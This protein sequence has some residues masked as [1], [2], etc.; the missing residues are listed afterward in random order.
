M[1]SLPKQEADLLVI[2]D[3]PTIRKLLV[4]L[5]RRL[6]YRARSASDGVEGLEAVATR[7]PDLILTDVVMPRVDGLEVVRRL[8]A[9]A[10]TRLIPVVVLTALDD[11]ETRMRAL[12]LGADELLTKPVQIRELHV[13]IR[14]LLGLKACIDELENAACVLTALAEA[15]EARDPHTGRHCLRLSTYSEILGREMNLSA[16]E[17]LALRHGGALH[18]L[19]KIAV[20]DRIL[21]KDGP[22]TPEEWRVMRLHTVVG[23]QIVASMKSM[24]LVAPIVRSHH[25][26]WDGTGY[27]DG[28]AGERIPLLARI[29]QV[30]DAYDAMRSRR[31]YKPPWPREEALSVLGEETG[32]GKWDPRIVALFTRAMRGRVPLEDTY[33]EDYGSPEED[34]AESPAVACEGTLRGGGRP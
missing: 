17:V 28:L 5:L 11:M 18:D 21:L 33:A 6:G 26:K 8:K 24:R 25:E 3:Q 7:A 14:N 29:V 22:L 30:V 1:S 13:R 15:V 27:P 19:G 20:P 9:D 32:R 10:A 4:D 12:E 23:E 2:E 31:A 34:L 16:E